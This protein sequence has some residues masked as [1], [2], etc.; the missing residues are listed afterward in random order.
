MRHAGLALSTSAVALFA[1][2]ALFALMRRRLG[3][4]DGRTLA[5][6][7]AKIAAASAIMGAVCRASSLAVH[8][9]AAP[10]RIAHLTDIA[11]SIP[12]GVAIFYTT[13]RALDVPELEALKAACYTS[14]SNAPRFELGDPPPGHR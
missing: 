11:I 12:L 6:N 10:G 8:A 14:D 13:A 5:A 2:A 1:A 3:S 9:I 4:L 7:A